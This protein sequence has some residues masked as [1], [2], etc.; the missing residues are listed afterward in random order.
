ME[1][2]PNVVLEALACGR[3]VVGSRVGGIPDALEDLEAGMLVP[4]QDPAALAAALGA[5]LEKSWDVDA[6]RRSAPGSWE[7]SADALWR[8]LSEA[9]AAYPR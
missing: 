8:V 1:G 3:P 5:A 9:H 6:V 2:Q 4:A 7:Q